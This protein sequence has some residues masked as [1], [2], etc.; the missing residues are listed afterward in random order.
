M[1][2][3]KRIRKEELKM[4]FLKFIEIKIIFNLYIYFTSY[5]VRHSL[6]GKL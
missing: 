6:E 5:F 4:N 2:K 3:N 1:T